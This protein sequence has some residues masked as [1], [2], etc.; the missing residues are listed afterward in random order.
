MFVLIS[1]VVAVVVLP[2]C[3]TAPEE[4]VLLAPPGLQYVR[5]WQVTHHRHEHRA[6]HSLR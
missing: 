5:V 4:D 2:V 6:A 3:I 1:R